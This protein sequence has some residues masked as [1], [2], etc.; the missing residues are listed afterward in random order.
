M[1]QRYCLRAISRRAE[2]GGFMRPAGYRCWPS[3][4]G[5]RVTCFAAL[6]ESGFD[7]VDSSFPGTRVPKKWAAVEAPT[8]RRSYARPRSCSTERV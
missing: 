6:H 3:R 7:A 5:D 2:V 8:I 4:R 1:P